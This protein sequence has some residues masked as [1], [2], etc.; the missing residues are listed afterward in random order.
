MH[1][2]FQ[3]HS[4]K[5]RIPWAADLLFWIALGGLNLLLF[6]PLYLFSR[7]D[8][9]SLLAALDGSLWGGLLLGRESPDPLRVNVEVCLLVIGVANLG[10]LRRPLVGMLFTVLYMGILLYY[11]YE[12][13]IYAFYQSAPVFYSDYFLLA[14]NIRFVFRNLNLPPQVWATVILGLLGMGL[15]VYAL[16]RLLFNHRLLEGLSRSTRYGLAALAL[17]LLMSAGFNGAESAQPDRVISSVIA[18]LVQN[19]QESLRLYYTTQYFGDDEARAFYSYSGLRLAD[20]P[21][22]YL[23]F[24]ESYGS[25]L[26]RRE[27]WAVVYQDLLAEVEAELSGD[28]WEMMSSMSAAPIWGGGSWLSYTS[29]LFG[30]PVEAESV[31]QRLMEE[32]LAQPFP[33][34]LRFARNQGYTTYRMTAISTPLTGSAAERLERFFDVDRWIH[35]ADLEYTGTRYNWGAAPPDQYS[36]NKAQAIMDAESGDAPRF[37]FTLTQS[38]HYPWMPT[39]P[40]LE[41]W[42][43]LNLLPDETV[44]VDL[45]EMPHDQ[46]RRNYL[47]AIDYNL[48]VISD[49][50]RRH[51][52]EDSLFILI[53]DHQPPRVSR[54]EDTL[55]T[56]IHIISRQPEISQALTQAGFVPGLTMDDLEPTMAHQGLYSLVVHLLARWND[57]PTYRTPLF[58][59]EGVPLEA[60]QESPGGE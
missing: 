30:V 21:D 40:I 29:A 12:S 37:F 36:L 15:L 22:V 19:V 50:I 14:E 44:Y 55:D 45:E 16:I 3:T 2:F 41:D 18:K 9:P 49:F 5:L 32:D 28:G 60:R 46:R 39:P 23:I 13:V 48:R 47:N 26:Y 10:W 11:V 34:L 51:G 31:Y 6:L 54:R 17:V 20:K 38:S 53:G 57:L 24:V 7:D 1:K 35:Y 42:R 59:P 8:T 4:A 27:D 52:D 43:D 33:H 56:P 58:L 25:V